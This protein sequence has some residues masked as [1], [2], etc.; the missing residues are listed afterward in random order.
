MYGFGFELTV[1]GWMLLLNAMFAAYE[2]A[3]AS[4]S[5]VR[6]LALVNQKKK[7]ALDALYM[8]ERMEASLAVIQIGITLVGAIAAATG[9]AGISETLAPWLREQGVSPHVAEAFALILFVIPL[10]VA[11]MI[12]GELVPKM[13]ALNNKEAVCLRLSPV[14]KAIAG[15]AYPLVSFLEKTVKRLVALFSRAWTP[16]GR[17]EGQELHEL[18]AAVALAKNARLLGPGE[19]RIVLAAAELSARPVAAVMLPVEDISMIWLGATL[20]EALIKAHLDMHTRFPVCEQENDPQTIVGYINFKDI[21]ATLNINPEDPSIRGIMRPIKRLP[22]IAKM[23]QVLFQMIQEKA[24]VA[25]LTGSNGKI[26]G[27]ITLEDILEE[28]VGDI[29]DEYDR[30]PAHAHAYGATWIMGGGVTMGQLA[31]LTGLCVEEN[32]RKL[33]ADWFEEKFGKT[34]HGADVVE[35]C[36]LAITAR[37]LRR[38]RLYEAVVSVRP[39]GDSRV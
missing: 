21:V 18:K 30:L 2:M 8:K 34:P 3:L 36:G 19:E 31:Q 12:F 14:F 35:T 25:V 32:S 29:E 17:D 38:N 16:D 24:H 26:V 10:S 22:A 33:L 4:V 13:F 28:L 15:L 11:T 7:G 27:F 39:A 37:K 6:L 23:S 5:R 1:I 9:G 20:T